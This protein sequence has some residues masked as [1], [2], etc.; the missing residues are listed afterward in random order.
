MYKLNLENAYD[1]EAFEKYKEYYSECFREANI[2]EEE[3][4][5][6]A[7]GRREIFYL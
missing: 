7:F 5:E 1:T 4:K 3:E 6:I 2:S